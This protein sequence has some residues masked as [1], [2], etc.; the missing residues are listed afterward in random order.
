MTMVASR[1][2]SCRTENYSDTLHDNINTT[3]VFHV[4]V[5]IY[6]QSS[7]S[8]DLIHQENICLY[9]G[10]K[11]SKPADCFCKCAL[12]CSSCFWWGV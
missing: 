9:Q 11:I 2:S 5:S 1:L 3:V 4:P 12:Q 8:H 6:F 7:V 10:E